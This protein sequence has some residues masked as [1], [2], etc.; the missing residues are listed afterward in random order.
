MLLAQPFTCTYADIPPCYALV[1]NLGFVRRLQASKRCYVANIA[2]SQTAA[3]IA[4]SLNYGDIYQTIVMEGV[5]SELLKAVLD[6]S[7]SNEDDEDDEDEDD[8]MQEDDGAS[9]D[10]GKVDAETILPDAS[11]SSEKV[12]EPKSTASDNI[13]FL[14]SRLTFETHPE[15]GEERCL[16]SEGNGVMMGWEAPIMVET[17]RLLCSSSNSSIAEDDDE[18]GFSVLNVGFGLGI[19][20]SELQ[21]YGKPKRHIIIEP[22]RDV[23]EHARKK[24]W[25]EKP[26]VEIYEG[27]WQDYMVAFHAGEQ[28]AEF[29]AIYVSQ[30]VSHEP[31]R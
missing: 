12:A 26:G 23:L 7:A 22:H 18:D 10:H 8:D 31:L 15:T 17:A 9:E 29:D 27:T 5:R 20:D 11:G 13:A 3:D 24:G 28:R 6:A 16:D 1:D 25:Y 19:V 14:A 2:Y 30:R 21:K 4:Y